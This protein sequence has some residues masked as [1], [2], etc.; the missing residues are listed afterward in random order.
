MSNEIHHKTFEDHYYESERLNMEARKELALLRTRLASAE[1]AL[2]KW[3]QFENRS[4]EKYGDYDGEEIK[5]LIRNGK[6][7]FSKFKESEK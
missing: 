3:L 6:E 7:H 1:E 4:I 2:G 5:G